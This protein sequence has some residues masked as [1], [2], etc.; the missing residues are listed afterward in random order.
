MSEGV[1]RSKTISRRALLYKLQRFRQMGIEI[2]R[3]R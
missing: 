1:T 2:D 3:E